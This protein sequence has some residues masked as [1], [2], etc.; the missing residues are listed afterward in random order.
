MPKKKSEILTLFK[1]DVEIK[2]NHECLLSILAM[3]EQ[4]I[5]PDYRDYIIKD[6]RK[7]LVKNDK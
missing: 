6:M 5:H 2:K 1:L 4:D 3:L 7:K